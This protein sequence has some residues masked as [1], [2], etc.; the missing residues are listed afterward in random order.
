MGQVQAPVILIAEDDNDINHMLTELLGSRGYQTQSAFSGTEALL[1]IERNAPAAVVLDLMLPGMTGQELLARIREIDAGIV[2][3]VASARDDVC[4]RVELLRAGAD[5]YVVKPFDTEELLA[6][7]EAVLRR[8]G[9]GKRHGGGDE[10]SRSQSANTGSSSC[11][12]AIPGRYLP[13]TIST[14]PSGTGNISARTMRSMCISAISARSL[15]GQTAGKPIS[16][17]CGGSGLR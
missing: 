3:V 5:D 12:S 1:Y 8:K 9:Q 6:R 10:R 13:E 7:I 11:W 4:T 2:V 16:R 17:R 15:R 14:S